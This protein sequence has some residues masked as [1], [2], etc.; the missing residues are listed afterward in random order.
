M[1]ETVDLTYQVVNHG[2]SD[3]SGPGIVITAPSGTVLLPA[4]WCWTAGT[5]HEQ[6]PESAGLECNFESYFP[7]VHSGCGRV[8][9]TVQLKIKSKPGRDGS[10]RV[11][12]EIVPGTESRPGNNTVPIIGKAR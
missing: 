7:T 4:E 11:R 12:G 8:G 3:G 2:P 1:G 6:R 9:A 10:I 5:E